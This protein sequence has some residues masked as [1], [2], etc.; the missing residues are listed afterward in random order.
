[1]RRAL[2]DLRV[3]ALLAPLLACTGG[4]DSKSPDLSEG[5]GAGAG[6]GSTRALLVPTS[7]PFYARLEAPEA[8]NACQR[9]DQCQ[10]S[11]CSSETCAAEPLMS[12]CEVLD[13]QL[14]A[15]AACGC[16]AGACAWYTTDGATLPAAGGAQS[17]GGE[18][19][20]GAGERCGEATCG[21]GERCISYY[22]IAGPNGPM[23]HTC[24]IPCD[25]RAPDGGCPAG[26]RCVTIADGP[27]DICK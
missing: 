10:R 18:P 1:M 16:V 24:A 2:A 22:G 26:K 9:D 27:G 3:L 7:H 11:G 4:K 8:A 12:T 17:G 14:P 19:N 25:R 13:L 23:F 15:S 5:G 21:P 20:P 6:S